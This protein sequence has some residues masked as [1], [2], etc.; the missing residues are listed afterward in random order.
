MSSTEQADGA[1]GG[2]PRTSH[3]PRTA[4][5]AGGGRTGPWTAYCLK[6]SAVR[7]REAVDATVAEGLGPGGT[8]AVGPTALPRAGHRV[9]GGEPEPFRRLGVHALYATC[10]AAD[11]RGLTTRTAQ[12]SRIARLADRVAGR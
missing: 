1:K 9:R 4:V 5:S 6:K 11:R 3:S 7:L 2:T 10:R 8:G 12:S